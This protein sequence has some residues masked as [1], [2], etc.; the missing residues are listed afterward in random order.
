DGSHSM[1][2]VYSEDVAR[3]NLAAMQSDASDEVYNVASGQETSLLELLQ[4]LLR[5][6]GR[7]DLRPEFHAE[8]TVNPVR[9]RW[10]DV[11]K[12]AAQ[13]GFRAE[14]NLEEGLRRLIAWHASVIQRGHQQDY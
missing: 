5:V 3:A 6:A 14:T 10:A 9:R 1:D 8:R 13:L 4:T 12:A 7:E 2:F 11:S